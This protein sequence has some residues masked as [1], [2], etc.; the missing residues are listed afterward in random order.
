MPSSWLRVA[1]RRLAGQRITGRRT[2]DPGR[3]FGNLRDQARQCWTM[4]FDGLPWDLYAT[5]TLPIG[6]RESADFALRCLKKWRRDMAR[7]HGRELRLAVGLELQDRGT[8]HLHVL[9]YGLTSVDAATIQRSRA[10]WRKA[11]GGGRADIEAYEVNGGAA[12]YVAKCVTLDITPLLIGPWP[13]YAKRQRGRRR[14]FP[15]ES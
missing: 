5:M 7:E 3:V 12:S 2:G 1:R 6:G 11:S 15:S 9:G 4:W 14:P 8:A 13:T 10:Y